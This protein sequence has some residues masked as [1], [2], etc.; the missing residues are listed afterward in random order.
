[1]GVLGQEPAKPTACPPASDTWGSSVGKETA[2]IGK[3][4]GQR[5]RGP[6][7]LV[8]PLEKG[9]GQRRESQVEQ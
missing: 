4:S 3:A 6:E 7:S 8:S 5:I 2:Q 1:M 9:P